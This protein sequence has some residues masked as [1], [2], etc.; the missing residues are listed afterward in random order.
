[1][2]QIGNT[3]SRVCAPLGGGGSKE[4]SLI[5]FLATELEYEVVHLELHGG[6]GGLQIKGSRSPDQ[7]TNEAVLWEALEAG[8]TASTR[9][10]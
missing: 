8:M 10:S 3:D 4:N 9:L 5:V 2:S 1:M 6:A 7:S